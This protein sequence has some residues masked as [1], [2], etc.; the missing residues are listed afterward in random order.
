MKR[1]LAFLCMIAMLL[2]LT[3]CVKNGAE[4]VV[5]QFCQSMQKFD[6]TAMGE[7][8]VSEE[9]LRETLENADE[10]TLTL[11][12][13]WEENAEKMTYEIEECKEVDDHTEVKVKFHFVDCS[14]LFLDAFEATAINLF[15]VKSEQE[16]QETYSDVFPRIFNEKAASTDPVMIDREVTFSCVKDESGWKIEKIPDDALTV[17]TCNMQAA[18][19]KL[20]QL[21]DTISGGAK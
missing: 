10:M 12:S 18:F 4:K 17:I 20:N 7:A 19:D 5:D 9:D 16:E 15:N 2:S 21:K 6:L 3:A 8:S 1:I 14:D 13:Y 11:Y